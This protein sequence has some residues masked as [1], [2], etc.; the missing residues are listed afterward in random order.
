MIKNGKAKSKRTKDEYLKVV[1]DVRLE[2]LTRKDSLLEEC[3]TA[4]S[5]KSPF[6]PGC[7]TLFPVHLRTD[8]GTIIRE[9]RQWARSLWREFDCLKPIVDK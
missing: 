1:N 5:N 4:R 7:A 8:V 3:T 2:L 6:C 9:K